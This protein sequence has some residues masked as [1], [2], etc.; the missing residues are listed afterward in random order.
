M[1]DWFTLAGWILRVLGAL[2]VSVLALLGLWGVW[3]W[4]RKGDTNDLR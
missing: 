3:C 1:I 2:W 4:T